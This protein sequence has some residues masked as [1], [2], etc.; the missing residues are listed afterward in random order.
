MAGA[1][2]GRA[3]EGENQMQDSYVQVSGNLTAD[4]VIRTFPSGAVVCNFRIG[5]SSRWRDR[6]SGQWRDGEATF[7]TVSCW[8]QLA[9]NA[10]ESLHK[11]DR[12]I[13]VGRLRDRSWTTPEGEQRTSHEIDADT[14]GPDLTRH[15]ASLRKSY[16]SAS[17]RLL[18]GA[19]TDA[20]EAAA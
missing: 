9:E 2:T 12:V 1:R 6:Q 18:K 8:R 16:R 3:A 15:V 17:S 14:V 19:G 7:Y 5:V 13:V 20:S 4:P 10:S 11:G